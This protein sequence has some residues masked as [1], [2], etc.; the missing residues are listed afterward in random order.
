M[1]NIIIR[2]A[3]SSDAEGIVYVNTYTWLTTYKGLLS[4]KILNNRLNTMKER[5]I[6]LAKAIEEKDNTY[7]ATINNKVVGFVTYGKSRNDKYEDSGE[8]NAIYV[9]EEYQKLG[10]GKAL[11]FKAIERL[12]NL[13]YQSMML[14]VLEGN[15]TIN[16]YKKY[17]GENIDNRYDYFGEDLIK[18]NIMYFDNIDKIVYRKW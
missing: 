12:I 8:I 4:D 18:E 17:G 13:G 6:K 7:V 15:N 11:F 2:Q 16:F 3:L 1:D 9:L 14:N 5:T 10:I